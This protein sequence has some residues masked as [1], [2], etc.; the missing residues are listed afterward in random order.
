MEVKK[1]MNKKGKISSSLLAVLVV[2]GLIVGGIATGFIDLSGLG[3]TTVPLPG[4]ITPATGCSSNTTPELE[5][6]ALDYIN[7]GTSRTDDMNAVIYLNGAYN[8][9]TKLSSDNTLDVSPGDGYTIFLVGTSNQYSYLGQIA[10]GNVECE[11]RTTIN[12]YPPAVGTPKISFFNEDDELANSLADTQTIG[13]GETVAMPFEI[14]A[15][16]ADQCVGTVGSTKELG[17]C[18]DYNSVVYKVPVLKI[19]GASASGLGTPEGH[20]TL[21]STHNDTTKCYTLSGYRELCD[22]AKIPN[23]ALQLEAKSGKNPTYASDDL[24]VWVYMP[25]IDKHQETNVYDYVYSD[26]VDA[27]III[28]PTSKAVHTT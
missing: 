21:R 9:N 4:K 14:K 19:G 2:A 16:S 8:S 13:S 20:T 5:I 6:V 15:N 28:M 10:T 26:E 18:I 17:F 25:Q 11:E 3:Q 1:S 23:L 24:N 7:Q 12:L 22:F 27:N